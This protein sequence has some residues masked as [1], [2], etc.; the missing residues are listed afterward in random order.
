MSNPLEEK[1]FNAAYDGLASEVSSLLRD[2]PK[3]NVN[4]ADANQRTP[5]HTASLKGHV[6]IVK[7]LLAHP[8]INVNLKIGDGD[9]PLSLGCVWGKVSVVKLLVK[10]PHVD[11]TLDDGNGCT[12]LWF[13]SRWGYG[14][15]V[16][17]L[18]ASGRNLGDVK[19][20]KG[21][22]W[23]DYKH[24]TAL[25]IARKEEA[26]EVISVL[27]NFIANPVQTRHELRVKLGMFFSFLEKTEHQHNKI[28]LLPL[29]F[30]SLSF[31]FPRL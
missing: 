20:K 27:E 1:L 8:N 23:K 7:L 12:P 4:W 19:N 28:F 14:E 11:A 3:I 29:A 10:D 24:Y 13:A 9:T 15:V 16:E 25:E 31:C 30:H 5:L 22:N 6:E 26:T 17:W 18:I 21:K 2:H